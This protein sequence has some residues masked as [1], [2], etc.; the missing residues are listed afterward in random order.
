MSTPI[1]LAVVF[2]SENIPV[3]SWV[4]ICSP[5]SLNIGTS[6]TPPSKFW[7]SSFSIK[8]P[9]IT[10]PTAPLPSPP[11]IWSLGAPHLR[12]LPELQSNCSLSSTSEPKILNLP[13]SPSKF[14]IDVPIPA[15]AFDALSNA[16]LIK[17]WLSVPDG[18][19]F[20]PLFNS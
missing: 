3:V 17:F 20:E 8:L 18:C 2:I 13:I 12:T 6:F 11:K 19:G 15:I 4:P 9:S 1:I 10:S 5:A 14:S 16:L 7:V